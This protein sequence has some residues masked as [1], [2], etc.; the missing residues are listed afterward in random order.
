VAR[1]NASERAKLPDSAFAYVDARGRRRLPINDEAHVR[2]ALARFEQVR[3][4]DDAA[5]ERARKRLLNAAKKYGIVP[6]GFITG[7]LQSERTHAA[8]GRLVIELGRMEAPGELEQQL[9]SALRDPTL[10]VVHW[11]EGAGTYLDGAG[12]PVPLPPDGS[13]RAVTYLERNGRPMTALVH[14]PAVL[15]D[16]KLAD[17]VLAAVRFVVENERLRGEVEARSTDAATLPTGFVTF[18]LLDIEGSTGLLRRLGDRYAGLLGDVRGIIRGVVLRAGGREVDARADE[19]FAV[20]ERVAA[21]VEAALGIQR[22]LNARTWPDGLD[23]RVRAG[24]HSG[25]PTLTETGYIGLSVHTASRVCDAAHG[26][27]IVVTEATRSALEQS[28]PPGVR[29]RGLGHHRLPGLPDAEALFE[30]E[31]EGLSTGFP[32]PRRRTG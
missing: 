17:T 26:G 23:V 20:F 12:R 25:R 8:A 16:E 13:E 24:I 4:E 2:N 7:Q 1:L 14:R 19:F 15:D 22:A 11:S 9:R 6:V 30:V 32:P 21:A 31:A 18:L 5:R 27:Q 3:F 10:T 28:P 29:L